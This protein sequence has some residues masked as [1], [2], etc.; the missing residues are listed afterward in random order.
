M[1]KRR[2]I[3]MNPYFFVKSMKKGEVAA[4]SPMNALVDTIA[5]GLICTQEPEGTPDIPHYDS[6]S[7]IKPGHL[8]AEK[9][10]R[11]LD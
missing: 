3:D 10:M 2:N 5:A 9:I 4:E 1:A 8:F 11:Y 6:M 7:E